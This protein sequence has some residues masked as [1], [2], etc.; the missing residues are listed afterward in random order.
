M[1]RADVDQ[2]AERS[3]NKWQLLRFALVGGAAAA[4]NIVS[5]IIL[6]RFISF[7]LAVVVA[8]FIG[9]TFAFV[10]NRKLVFQATDRPIW[11]EYLRFFLV[12]LIA[13]VQVW[14]VSIALLNWLL[15]TIGW[16]YFVELT[17]HVI[18]VCSPIL[19]SYYA[20]K[21]FTFR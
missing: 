8:Y 20:H 14:L 19:T 18:A 10:L 2:I 12:N 16:T 3:H 7:E 15:P 11:N 9:M 5:R 13:L 17:A 21:F 6:S 4:I 1:T